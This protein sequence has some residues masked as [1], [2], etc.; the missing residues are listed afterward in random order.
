[1]T[2]NKFLIFKCNVNGKSEKK[3][4]KISIIKYKLFIFLQ[5]FFLIHLKVTFLLLT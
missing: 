1:M 5:I 3:F 2:K 4:I